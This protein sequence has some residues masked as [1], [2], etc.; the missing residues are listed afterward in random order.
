MSGD[1]RSYGR[2]VVQA[3]RGGALVPVAG[4]RVR[5]V[6]PGTDTPYGGAL[7][8]DARSRVP[9]TFPVATDARGVLELW[10][11]GGARL[12]ALCAAPGY[13]PRRLILDLTAPPEAAPLRSAAP[14]FRRDV[15]DAVG[16]APQ[17]ADDFTRAFG[18][19]TVFGFL[20]GA[21]VPLAGALVWAYTPGTETPW[22]GALYGDPGATVP[23][24]FP[25]STDASGQLALWADAPGRVELRYQAVGYEAERTL[26]DLEP[27]PVAGGG[28]GP[29]GPPGPE[30]PPGATGAQGPTGATGAAGSPGATG[31]AGADGATGAPG[32]QGPQGIQGVQG[33]AGTAGTAGAQGPAGPGVPAGGATSQVLTKTSA[34]DYA[35]AWQTPA[36][37]GGGLPTTGGTM[38][39]SILVQ[40]TNAIDLGATATRW[41]KLW[42]VDAEF[43]NVPTIGGVS[44]D[45]RYQAAGTYL[46]QAAGDLRYEPIDTMYTKA[47]SDAKYALASALT[48]LTTRVATLEGQVATLNTRMAGHTHTTGTHGTMGG[49]AV[50]P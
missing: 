22:G 46:T 30:G 7:Y 48:A 39:G 45:T 43:T 2:L 32:A 29:P 1:A 11:P 19:T 50:L 12:E 26:L 49:T 21:S 35:T 34:T 14:V 6:E 28:A 38:T 44:M 27:P 33:P 15:P 36:G 4:A 10:G 31:P 24:A 8:G 17:D 18:Q 16:L 41:R 25:V 20:R 13:A 47:E 40:T 23:L 5:V 37:G 9:L 3:P 42:A